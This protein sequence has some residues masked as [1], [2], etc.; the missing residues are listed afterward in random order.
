MI[1]RKEVEEASAGVEM[2]D[3]WKALKLIEVQ[4]G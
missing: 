3:A 4:P 1:L 2:A